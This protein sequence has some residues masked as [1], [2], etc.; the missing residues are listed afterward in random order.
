MIY[1]LLFLV[2]YFFLLYFF[3]TVAGTNLTEY[4]EE[5]LEQM[6]KELESEEK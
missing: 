6:L 3:F 1:S 2:I 4:S 5:E